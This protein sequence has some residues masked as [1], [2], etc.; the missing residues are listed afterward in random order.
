M[1]C[2]GRAVEPRLSWLSATIRTRA[3]YGSL[4]YCP[5]RTTRLASEAPSCT[6]QI[7]VSCNTARRIPRQFALPHCATNNSEPHIRS[8]CRGDSPW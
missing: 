5:T 3:T 8:R 4:A 1:A 7:V 6:D 2:T